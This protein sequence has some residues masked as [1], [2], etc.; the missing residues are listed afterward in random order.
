MPMEESL[1]ETYIRL[2]DNMEASY[3]VY[4]ESPSDKSNQRYRLDLMIFQDFCVAYTNKM[5]S[6]AEEFRKEIGY[7]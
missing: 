5:M 6:A 4:N 2:K 1:Y 7:M 3:R